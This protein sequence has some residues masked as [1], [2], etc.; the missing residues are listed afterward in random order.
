VTPE[1][2]APIA[3][4]YCD[5]VDRRE[6]LEVPVFLVEIRRA[7]LDACRAVIDL[8][9]DWNRDDDLILP[10]RSSEQWFELSREVARYLGTLDEAEETNL[11]DDLVDVYRDLTRGLVALEHGH[12]DEA[13]W[14]WRWGY[15]N[16][17]GRNAHVALTSIHGE[18]P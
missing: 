2:F 8:P 3:R 16:H 6:A 10:D 12:P 13:A 18:V 9:L 11:G 14:A 1:S 4:A 7:L 5:V 17:W 15:D